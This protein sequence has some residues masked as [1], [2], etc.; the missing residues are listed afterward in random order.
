MYLGGENHLKKGMHKNSM[1]HY[2]IY[3]KFIVYAAICL[4]THLKESLEY[5]NCGV[6]HKRP[7]IS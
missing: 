1:L 4:K 3:L 6:A 7:R 5:I 2:S